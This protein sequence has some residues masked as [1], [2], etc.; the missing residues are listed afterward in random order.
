[1]SEV[2]QENDNMSNLHFVQFWRKYGKRFDE[3]DKDKL[4]ILFKIAFTQG[5][6]EGL[7]R[8]TT[9]LELTD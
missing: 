4:S 7:R 8:Q 2:L 9:K 1:M 5:M 3:A 6:I